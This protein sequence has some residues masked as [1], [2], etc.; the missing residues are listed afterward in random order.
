M[1]FSLS[2]MEKFKRNLLNLIIPIVDNSPLSAALSSVYFS[3]QIF[4]KKHTK[5]KLNQYNAWFLMRFSF[6][7]HCRGGN[8][9]G[10]D[11]RPIIHYR[12]LDAP[13]EP[14]DFL[15]MRTHQLDSIDTL[16]DWC[17]HFSFS[18]SRLWST[19][20]KIYHKNKGSN[21]STLYL[22]GLQYIN[23]YLVLFCQSI[24]TPNKWVFQLH[25]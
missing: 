16:T 6:I 24:Y 19:P 21:M 2:E 15:W 20:I 1:F 8:H 22:V 10:G 23:K 3:F 18:R 14:D 12:D 9:G 17:K 25:K 13:R 4:H 11:Y 7:S 5:P